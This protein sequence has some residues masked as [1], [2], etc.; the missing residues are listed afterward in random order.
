MEAPRYSADLHSVVALQA[1]RYSIVKLIAT[2]RYHVYGTRAHSSNATPTCCQQKTSSSKEKEVV[3]TRA[4]SRNV[5][6]RAG[7]D[8]G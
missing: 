5:P 6:S 1:E 3:L 7:W 8:A 4:P 2:R